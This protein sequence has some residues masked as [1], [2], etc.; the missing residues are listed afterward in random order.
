MRAPALRRLFPLILFCLTGLLPLHCGAEVNVSIEVVA[1]PPPMVIAGPPV[2]AVVPGTTYVYFVPGVREDLLFYR[3]YW[4]R[5]HE[6]RWFRA[7]SYR[8][9]WVYMDHSAVSPVLIDLPSDY[10][11][12][13][14][15]H[16]KIPYGHVR[17]NWKQWEKE[18]HWDERANGHHNPGGHHGRD[19]GGRNNDRSKNDG[20]GK[21]KS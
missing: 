16:Q 18:H 2:V 7:R 13:P 15:G 20:K 11:R 19:E 1:P 17:K 10:R 3:G 21:G 8:G 12:I 6:G 5:P 4:Y 14:P 9:P